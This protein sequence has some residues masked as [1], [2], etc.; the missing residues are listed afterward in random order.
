MVELHP[1]KKARCRALQRAAS[2]VSE[3]GR[4]RL[5]NKKPRHRL[6]LCRGVLPVDPC[7]AGFFSHQIR[8]L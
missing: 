1:N 6:I 4:H 3:L 5:L 7:C 8:Q 2:A